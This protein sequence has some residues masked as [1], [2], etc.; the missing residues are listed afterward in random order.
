[1]TNALVFKGFPGGNHGPHGRFLVLPTETSMDDVLVFSGTRKFSFSYKG[2]TWAEFVRLMCQ[3]MF[4]YIDH[5]S[6]RALVEE[7]SFVSQKDSESFLV[8]I[9][10][11]VRLV[12][13]SGVELL[14]FISDWSEYALASDGRLLP[15]YLVVDLGGDP[16][17]RAV[18]LRPS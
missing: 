2:E 13:S 15:I 12:Q 5:P 4:P 17:L 3:S 7:V 9:R 14:T 18:P 1:M 10:N 6:E 16:S 11:G 8:Q